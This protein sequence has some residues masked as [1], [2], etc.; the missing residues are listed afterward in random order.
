MS[1]S[2]SQPYPTNGGSPMDIPAVPRLPD[3]EELRMLQQATAAAE[4]LH[5]QYASLRLQEEQLEVRAGEVEAL[6]VELERSRAATQAQA[7]RREED[8]DR[9]RSE[10]NDLYSQFNE[11]EKTI[12]EYE[13]RLKQL[14]I[15][16]QR[17]REAM[18]AEVMRE[19]EVERAGLLQLQKT[20]TVDR[21]NFSLEM[22][23]KREKWEN[24]LN[25]RRENL[26]R[27]RERLE[28]AVRNEVN[29]EFEDFRREKGEWLTDHQQKNQLLHDQME[30]LQQQREQ[31]ENHLNGERQRMESE[32]AI[33]RDKFNREQT[34]L[35]NRYRFQLEH[36]NRS[37]EELDSELRLFRREKQQ[38]Q[39]D[40][41]DFRELHQQRLDQFEHYRQL[42]AERETAIQRQMQLLQDATKTQEAETASVRRRRNEDREQ[43]D[44]EQKKQRVELQ[45]QSELLAA[46]AENLEERHHRLDELRDELEHTHAATLEA[47]IAVEEIF[48]Q[49]SQSIS[50]EAAEERVAGART[51]ISEHY[52]KLRD[53]LADER[54]ELNRER[55][56]I[57]SKMN[58]LREVRSELSDWIAEREEKL[59]LK[60][61]QLT[62]YEDSSDEREQAWRNA[63]RRWQNER[64]EA[65]GIIR[66]LLKQIS[67]IHL[68]AV[69]ATIQPSEN[70]ITQ[71]QTV[72][73]TGQIVPDE[74]EPL[75]KAD[76][77]VVEPDEGIEPSR[78]AA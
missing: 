33:E 61:V 15:E 36:L 46:Q 43:W 74:L 11:R 66:D 32:L 37:R 57:D 35:G 25:V 68:P 3:P 4:R 65:E 20:F 30:E 58:E 56:T 34:V 71:Y 73:D 78:E 14:E 50:P 9:K 44:L 2:E 7:E 72:V 45:R 52:R 5:A 16:L 48:A 53:S 69:A 40:S 27:E 26:D 13:E 60:D 19:V 41:T 24:E 62:E 49:I 31:F 51:A 47:R 17:K 70:A 1:N 76:L 8:I 38:L 6:R 29:A 54:G 18:T 10:L 21:D 23:Q 39:V 55:E 42:L 64:I 77:D 12:A 63:Q 28:G 22:T 67:D 75:A 59:R